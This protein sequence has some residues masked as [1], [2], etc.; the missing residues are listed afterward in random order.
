[1]PTDKTAACPTPQD[2]LDALLQP[3]YDY[4]RAQGQRDLA[5][6]VLGIGVQFE[7]RLHEAAILAREAARA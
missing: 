1:M 2:Q 3:A 4:L 7:R 6:Q 5:H